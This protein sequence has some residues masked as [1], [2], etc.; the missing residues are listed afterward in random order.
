MRSVQNTRKITRTMELVSTSKLKR[1][2]DRVVAARPY[3]EALAE[4]IGD[5]VTPELME[6][7]P[8]L[9]QPL[10]PSK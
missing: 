2:Q 8:L 10:P 1:A 6:K 5:L 9:Q 7:F 3:A 4:V